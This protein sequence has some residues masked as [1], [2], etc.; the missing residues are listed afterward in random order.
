MEDRSERRTRSG[1]QSLEQLEVVHVLGPVVVARVEGP[2]LLNRDARH[3]AATQLPDRPDV[4]R[5]V[6][7][8][9]V[10]ALLPAV[11]VCVEPHGMHVDPAPSLRDVL[12]PRLRGV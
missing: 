9:A 5:V 8:V 10:E 3:R 7:V 12:D 1:V 6:E 11:A 4:R 2:L